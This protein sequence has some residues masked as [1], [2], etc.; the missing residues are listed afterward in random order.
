MEQIEALSQKFVPSELVQQWS[1]ITT[2]SKP[3]ATSYDDLWESFDPSRVNQA[4]PMAWFLNP[5]VPLALVGAY[6]VGE[7]AL[8]KIMKALKVPAFSG[9]L[10]N[11]FVTLH[12]FLLTAYSFITFVGI[13]PLVVRSVEEKGWLTTFCDNDGS[14]WQAGVGFWG[15]LFYVSKYWEFLDTIIIVFKGKDPSFLQVY[16]HAG[17][18]LAMYLLVAAQ[19]T[20]GLFVIT[21]LNSFIHTLMYAY[22]TLTANVRLPKVIANIVRPSLTSFQLIQF[23]TG[24]GITLQKHV[25]EDKDT[26]V[27]DA[28]FVSLVFVQVYAGLLIP[29]FGHFFA[30]QYILKKKKNK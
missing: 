19:E 21:T 15:T 23:F 12:S 27:S 6:L 3:L 30:S 16:H 4:N 7:F 9:P 29:L 17:V 14:L 13:L 1:V 28:Q 8:K 11:G 26:C 25:I 20:G 22:F 10:F 5:V 2:D 24:I 18:V